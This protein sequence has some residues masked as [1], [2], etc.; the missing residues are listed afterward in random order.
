[1][2]DEIVKAYDIIIENQRNA[3]NKSYIFIIVLSA[4]LT[5]MSEITLSTFSDN[6]R[7]VLQYIFYLNIIPLLFF[8]ISL[9][10][11][12]SNN[13]KTK[14]KDSKFNNFNLYFWRSILMCDSKQALIDKTIEQYKIKNLSCAERDL[15][16]Q[17]Y[18]N[19]LILENKISL[20]MFAFFFINQFIIIIFI[21]IIG[22]TILNGNIFFTGL[23]FFII[24]I[25][26][27]I[28]T[29]ITKV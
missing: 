25:L 16:R 20:Q 24:E 19:A 23:L 17:I 10:P 5:F 8:I 27:L 13:Y 11:K 12:Y 6:E 26:F 3:D 22:F 15:L 29:F 21:S 28:K 18:V 4:F 1:M 9:I 14:M 7:V 2:R